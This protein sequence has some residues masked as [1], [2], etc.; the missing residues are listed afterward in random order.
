M[1]LSRALLTDILASLKNISL[2]KFPIAPVMDLFQVFMSKSGKNLTP[3]DLKL[4]LR[5]QIFSLC[6]S[7]LCEVTK[8]FNLAC[9]TSGSIFNFY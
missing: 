4:D 9:F 7:A 3:P 1:N 6:D 8:L 2:E 5:T